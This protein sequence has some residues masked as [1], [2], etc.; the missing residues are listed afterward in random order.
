MTERKIGSGTANGS[1]RDEVRKVIRT[2][3]TLPSAPA[4]AT[5]ILN[6][7]TQARPDM[8]RVV[9]LL[10]TDQGLAMKLLRLVNSSYY[11]FSKK[12]TTLHRAVTLLGMKQLRCMLL[13]V[14]VSESLIKELRRRARKDQQALWEHSLACAVCCELFAEKVLP[15][16]S[17]EAF[18]LGLL[19][20]VGKLLFMECSAET[21]Q[22][23]EKVARERGVAMAEAEQDLLGVDHATVARWL[24]EK[25]DLPPILSFPL[26]WHHHGPDVLAL[27]DIADPEIRELSLLVNL[28]DHVVHELMADAVAVELFRSP[29]PALLA[30]F[31]LT[32]SDCDHIKSRIAKRYSARTALLDFEQD[33][34]S[35]YFSALQRANQ[36]LSRMASKGLRLEN[37]RRSDREREALE[38]LEAVLPALTDI[39]T[40]LEEAAGR[41]AEALG[42]DHGVVYVWDDA[43][44][45][46]YGSWWKT[47]DAPRSFTLFKEGSNGREALN[48]IP[49]EMRQLLSGFRKR[50]S[51]TAGGTVMDRRVQY[52][53]PYIAVPIVV[54]DL[55]L[56]EAILHEEG[57]HEEAAD[58]ARSL[59]VYEKLGRVLSSA[60]RQIRLVEQSRDL[61][62]KLS[63]A[64][65]QAGRAM[66]ELR[67]AQA[68]YRDEKERL[69]VTLQSIAEAVMATDTKGR[70]VLFNEAAAKLTGWDAQD[71]IGK[72][73]MELLRLLRTPD[74]EPLPDPVAQVLKKG[75]PV[76]YANELALVARDGS[77]KPV[78]LCGAPITDVEGQNLGVIFAVRDLTYQKKMEAEVLRARKLDSLRILAGGIAHDFNNIMMS[79]LGNLNLARMFVNEP[80]KMERRLA[81]AEKGVHRARDLTQQLLSLARGGVSTKKTTD[82]GGL[83]REGANFVLSG[84]NVKIHFD[85]P[86]DLRPVN[87]DV[88]Q[89]HQVI[90][91][92]LI[93]A[94]Q[95]M[96]NGGAVWISAKNVEVT[97]TSGLPVPDGAYVHV[98]FRDE[99]TGIK[100]EYLDRIFDPYFTTKDRT[101]ER[102]TGLGLAIVY[103]VMKRH[104][105]CVTV[106]SEEG[107]GTT[108]H[109]YLPVANTVPS[110]VEHNAETLQKSQG[111]IL[112]MDDEETVRTIVQEMLTHLGYE[113][114]MAAEGLEAVQK[115]EAALKSGRPF[116]AVILDLTVRG[117]IGAREALEGMR[118]LDPKVKAIVSSGYVQDEMIERYA[119]FGFAAVITKPFT[120]RKL[121]E[122]LLRIVHKKDRRRFERKCVQ[123]AVAVELAETSFWATTKNLSEEGALIDCQVPVNPEEVVCV[124]LKAGSEEQRRLMGRVVWSR[125]NATNGHGGSYLIGV[126]FE[127][128]SEEDR[129]F[130]HRLMKRES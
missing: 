33:E 23:V 108:F 104:G 26:W 67:E 48:G 82:L 47:H 17:S 58:A 14:T 69:A 79:I 84:S 122:T 54:D 27:M 125:V 73:A 130:M 101:S 61:N 13:S 81:E 70:V 110:P 37:V 29:D 2:L 117:G 46:L 83:I 107:K 56:G 39:S 24:A 51:F 71:A 89:M 90:S 75:G 64:L 3:E 116:D 59:A 50:Y 112:I 127:N 77:R 124:N 126:R 119:D 60:V 86:E 53:P 105:G 100:A 114:E 113:T 42:V 28:S 12:V 85:L 9:K 18:V 15:K 57:L 88:A 66:K 99:G 31:G 11:G 68:R 32:L 72:P 80:E 30:H 52:H 36:H 25:W 22:E 103:S 16:R 6:A 87:V 43:G 95:A 41:V 93:N 35:F 10:E 128:V 4:V 65:A 55:V 45:T 120:I 78:A 8:E 123:H 129:E 111:R 63:A 40:M 49:F 109:I 102:G 97:E 20:D 106:E 118:A 7:L 115:Y 94:K 5:N 91:N 44:P 96:P 1:L 98:A 121:R 76:E 34:L 21:Y 38:A 74:E 92:L 62:D 19:H